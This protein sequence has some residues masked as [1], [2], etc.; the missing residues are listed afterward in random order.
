MKQKG[1]DD[2]FK[3]IPLLN[4]IAFGIL[5]SFAI[6]CW[7]T[8]G[9]M[10]CVDDQNEQESTYDNRSEQQKLQDQMTEDPANWTDEEKA[11]L[12]TIFENETNVD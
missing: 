12:N 3:K 4:K 2:D 5:L 10:N 9:I 7:S 1:I 8:I 11:R 6:I